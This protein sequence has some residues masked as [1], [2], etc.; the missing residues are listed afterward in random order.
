[1]RP[2]LDDGAMGWLH[3]DLARGVADA[4][5]A[6]LQLVEDAVRVAVAGMRPATVGFGRRTTMVVT[7]TTTPSRQT[8]S[9]TEAATWRRPAVVLPLAPG[10]T[11][12]GIPSRT[13]PPAV[14]LTLTTAVAAVCAGPI[15]LLDGPSAAARSPSSFRGNRSSPATSRWL[16]PHPFLRDRQPVC[17]LGHLRA[18]D[19]EL[20]A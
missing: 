18:C 8:S 12:M 4:R 15:D 17:V 19:Q 13:D 11:G 9:A 2:H 20:I 16:V 7:R 3:P 10:C 5:R 6:L 1:M 14:G